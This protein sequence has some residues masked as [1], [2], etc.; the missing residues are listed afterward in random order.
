MDTDMASFSQGRS[1][2]GSI[3]ALLLVCSPLLPVA[4]VY[5]HYLVSAVELG[6]WPRASLDDPGRIG[7]I[8]VITYFASWLAMAI[9]P[10]LFIV[11][12][13]MAWALPGLWR[14]RSHW[15]ARIVCVASVMA[16]WVAAVLILRLDP[17]GVTEW[18]LD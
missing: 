6:H 1:R 5:T 16:A 9:S 17:L 8:A 14:E 15:A 7:G 4:A 11:S 2:L 18:W 10:P 12:A 3:V 13:V